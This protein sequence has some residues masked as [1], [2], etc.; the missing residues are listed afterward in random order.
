MTSPY[1]LPPYS[2]DSTSSI[3]SAPTASFYTMKMYETP[4]E[5]N[6]SATNEANSRYLPPREIPYH[7][8]SLSKESAPA[9]NGS[10]AGITFTNPFVPSESPPRSAGASPPVQPVI[11]TIT[12]SPLLPAANSTAVSNQAANSGSSFQPLYATFGR[13]PVFVSCPYCQHTD[14]TI[15]EPAI[16]MRSVL[17]C[18]AL[19][20]FGFLFKSKWDTKHKCKCCLNVIGT[21][22]A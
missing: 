12:P 17:C 22:Y 18:I 13:A 11:Q 1:T 4:V 9:A 20:V 21:H 19:P 6:R 10:S 16:G 7:H 8:S 3:H 5:T 14:E 2:H 15:A